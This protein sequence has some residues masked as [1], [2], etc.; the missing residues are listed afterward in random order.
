[1]ADARD[2]KFDLLLAESLDRISRDQ[3]DIAGVYKRLRFAGVRIITLSEGQISELHIGFKGTMGALHLKD[4]ADKTRR[5]L[6]GRVEA[7]KSGGCNS[8]G[9]DVVK[10]FTDTGEPERDARRINAREA[11]IVR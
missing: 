6:R 4:L 3:E 9:Y 1:M 8:Y 2:G 5:G 7:G 10:D 11:A